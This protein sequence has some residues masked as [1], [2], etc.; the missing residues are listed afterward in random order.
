M[1]SRK[2]SSIFL[3]YGIMGYFHRDFS[4]PSRRVKVRLDYPV[5]CAAC[6]MCH[7]I[8]PTAGRNF[9]LIVFNCLF[10]CFQFAGYC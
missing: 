5:M 2:S 10:V 3:D 8:L 9:L 6:K 1:C 4:F 7:A